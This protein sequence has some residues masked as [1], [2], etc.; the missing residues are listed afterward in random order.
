MQRSTTHK[1][2]TV[3][4]EAKLRKIIRDELSRKILVKEG[5]LDVF[6]KPFQKLSSEA[7]KWVT[8][9]S[10]ELAK[11]ISDS[12]ASLVVPEDLKTFLTLMSQQE[13]GVSVEELKGYLPFAKD[14]EELSK[15][16]DVDFAS[17]ASTTS[18]CI[19]YDDM[20]FA[21]LMAEEKYVMRSDKLSAPRYLNEGIVTTV[22]GTWYTVSKTVVTTCSLMVF[23]LEAAAKLSAY[24]GFKKLEHVLEGL[25]KKLEHVEEWFL[26]KVTFPEP[27]QY[28]AYLALQAARKVK[29]TAKEKTLSFKEFQADK[30]VKEAVLKGL[31]IALLVTIV[32]EALVHLG[33]SLLD[34]FKNVKKSVAEMIK[35]GEHI[36]LETRGIA[37][38]G[39]ELARGGEGLA[40]GASALA[41]DNNRTR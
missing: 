25:A 26:K 30:E 20:R 11:K 2:T 32:V 35:A 7:K 21:Y 9:K 39:S 38:I 17:M 14:L 40:A 23:A 31:K 12:L 22:V 37:K 10:T 16:K 27:V 15:L 18:E 36:G 5:F 19:S 28:A 41:A 34:F 1:R 29:G 3:V 24:L 4:T 8:E 33:H 6:K 13:G